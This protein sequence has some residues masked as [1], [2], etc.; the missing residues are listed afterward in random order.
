MKRWHGIYPILYAFWEDGGKLD[1]NAMR[2]QVE[3]CIATGAHGI[4][5][6]G[7]V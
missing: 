2:A 7:L 4:A 1:R 6:L 5:V 3:H